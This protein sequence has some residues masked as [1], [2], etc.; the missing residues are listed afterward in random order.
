MN[1]AWSLTIPTNGRYVIRT[2]FAAFAP[3][4]QETVLNASSHEQTMEFQLILASRA[5]QQEQREDSQS[6]QMRRSFGR[7]RR[8]G[9]RA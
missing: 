3:G 8:M 6:G 1:G 5:A 7:W 2:Q 4:A 9:R